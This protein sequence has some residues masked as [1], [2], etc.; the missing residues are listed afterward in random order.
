MIWRDRGSAEMQ[1]ALWV[2][3]FLNAPGC[4]LYKLLIY[5][6]NKDKIVLECLGQSRI[7]A[8]YDIKGGKFYGLIQNISVPFN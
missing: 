3:G 6:C 4:L 2:L 8:V 7:L 5:N 1:V